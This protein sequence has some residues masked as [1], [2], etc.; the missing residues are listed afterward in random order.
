VRPPGWAREP[1]KDL[2][3]ASRRQD[4]TTWLYASVP[5]VRAPVIAQGSCEPPCDP[6][7]RKHRCVHRIPFQRS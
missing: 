1:P 3:P 4:H 5:F 6:V 7:A 2:T